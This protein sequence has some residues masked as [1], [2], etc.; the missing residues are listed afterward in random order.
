[1]KIINVEQGT[2]EWFNARKGVPT[3]SAFSKIVTPAKGGKSASSKT[4]MYELLS[5][6]LGAE[7]EAG[8]SSEWM[9]RGIELEE[10]ARSLFELETGLLV[11]EVGMIKT[12]DGF[13]GCSPDG[14]IG[15]DGGIEIKC[16][17]ASTH[18]EY[19][20]EGVL[21]LKYKTQVMGSLMVSERDY[22]YFMSY[23][24]DL[25][26][27]ILKV[28]RDEEF[29]AKMK[30]HID[31]FV[32]ELNE[33]YDKVVGKKE[34]AEII[35]RIEISKEEFEQ[36]EDCGKK[37]VEDYLGDIGSLGD[38]ME[39]INENSELKATISIKDLEK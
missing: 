28:E 36:I 4:Y 3:A 35:P 26:P 38:L 15:E 14:L 12:D 11:E 16:P 13:I 23:H 7:T 17:K 10:M 19:M 21:P 25:E 5:E 9:E 37:L 27:F 33:K 1:M 2:E 8:F 18:V 24:P 22:W 6:K 29:I 31:D 32:K 39:E 34:D 20:I 30:S